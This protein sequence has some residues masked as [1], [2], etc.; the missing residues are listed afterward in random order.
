ML[1]IRSLF[2]PILITLVSLT[3]RH[4]FAECTSTP[5]EKWI[6]SQ[7]QYIGCSI[8]FD[9]AKVI[10]PRK[11]LKKKSC[12]NFCSRFDTYLRELDEAHDSIRSENTEG[13]TNTIPTYGFLE[14][15]VT[16]DTT[17]GFGAFDDLFNLSYPKLGPRNLDLGGGRFN[18]TSAYLKLFSIE[19][20]VYDPF[21]RTLAH[22][23]NVL[24]RS[25]AYD[26][27]TSISVLNVIETR[28]DRKAHIRQA[29]HALK[30]HGVAFFKI[31]EGDLSKIRSNFQNNSSTEA[32]LSEIED[33]FGREQVTLIADRYLIIAY[34]THSFSVLK[35]QNPQLR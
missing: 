23:E 13:S 7:P 28:E 8:L 27:V 21:G 19:N 24:A 29:L 4:S 15:G 10:Q 5:L 17:E 33:I 1:H 31:Y 9:N 18:H 35:T 34:K 26:S 30:P 12:K 32:Y 11:M 20:S 25:G 16:I 14:D 3:S 22:N 2:K 6:H